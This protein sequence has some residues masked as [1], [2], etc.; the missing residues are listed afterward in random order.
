[1]PPLSLLNRPAWS[2][3]RLVGMYLLRAYLAIAVVLLLVKAIQLGL[4]T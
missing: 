2:R 4:H 3:S 1:M